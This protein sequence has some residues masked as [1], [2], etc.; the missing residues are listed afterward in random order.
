MAAEVDTVPRVPGSF[1]AGVG[2]GVGARAVSLAAVLRKL[3]RTTTP[4]YPGTCDARGTRNDKPLK[5]KNKRRE[6]RA[7]LLGIRDASNW[8]QFAKL[9][10]APLRTR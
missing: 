3:G 5:S 9:G 4:R 1:S 2:W 8:N 10:L 6:D 7:R